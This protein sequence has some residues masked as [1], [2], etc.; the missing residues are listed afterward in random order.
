VARTGASGANRGKNF[1][2]RVNRIQ[3][4]SRTLIDELHK[5]E[6]VLADPFDI[7]GVLPK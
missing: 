3:G 5:R 4:I 1:F 2:D 6:K 7:E